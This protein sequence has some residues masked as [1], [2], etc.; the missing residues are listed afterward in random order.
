MSVE[1]VAHAE[2]EPVSAALLI[3]QL[4]LVTGLERPAALVDHPAQASVSGPLLR[5]PSCFAPELLRTRSDAGE[6]DIQV[7]SCHHAEHLTAGLDQQI[8][9]RRKLLNRL[10]QLHS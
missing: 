10:Y 2:H 4:D 5:T 9:A 3:G 7:G 1:C 8:L 6:R